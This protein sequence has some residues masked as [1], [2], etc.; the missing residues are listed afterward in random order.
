MKKK[1]SAVLLSVMLA[2][3]SLFSVGCGPVESVDGEGTKYGKRDRAFTFCYYAGGYGTDW[4]DAVLDDYMLNVN[5]DVYINLKRNTNNDTTRTNI[6]TG[7]GTYDLY[8]IEVDMFG[9]SNCLADMS[10]LYETEVYGEPGVKV[11]DKFGDRWVDY[12]EENGHWYQMPQTQL[13]GWNWAYNKDLLDSTLGAGQYS[14]PRTTEE[15]FAFGDELY[16]KGVYLTAFPGADTAGGDYSRYAYELWFAQMTGLEG[17]QKYMS[18]YYKDEQTGE[19]TFAEDA[20][21]QIKQNETAITEAYKVAQRLC[22]PAAS[23]ADSQYMHAQSMGMTFKDVDVMLYGGRYRGQK[24]P[25]IAF[26]YVGGWLETEVAPFV[27]AGT[28]S[29]DQK[30]MAM[31][32]P[33]ISAITSRTPT[34]NDEQTLLKVIDYV[35]GVAESAPQ[36]VTEGDIAV[37]REARNMVSELIC[38]QF[39]VTN[40]AQNKDDIFDFLAY[41]TS[42]RAQKIAAKA[43]RG[44]SV[45]PYGY[46]PTDEDMGF[47]ISDYTKSVE[48]IK[49]ESVIVDEGGLDMPYRSFFG[50]SWFVDSAAAGGTLSQNLF[51]KQAE[52]Y[53]TI[54]TSTYKKLNSTY[55]DVM[56][57]YKIKY[58][59]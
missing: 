43:T 56:A 41:L 50:M 35:D 28:I 53:K 32:M 54:A 24:V 18:G 11:K 12:Y 33:V 46:T 47:T 19:W 27:N 58:G 42:E 48:A 8:Q 22:T 45:L 39:V 36:G 25:P 49:R 52:D 26:S 40:S 59:L 51:T 37:V 7:V 9:C 57:Q 34:I 29:G 21:V 14:L 2:A 44:I 17:Y 23:A 6:K 3:V 4:L 5:T 38:R 16:K 20:P 31:K 15:F 10:E 55:K 13:T 1:I 30:V